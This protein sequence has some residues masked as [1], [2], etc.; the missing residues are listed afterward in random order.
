MVRWKGYD[1]SYDTWEPAEELEANA[2][3]A[4]KEFY[5]KHLNAPKHISA[6][7]FNNLPWRPLD[8][9]TTMEVS[10]LGHRL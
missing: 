5:W 7:V 10:S 9:V 4:V 6:T 2:L 3:E 1:E 8:N